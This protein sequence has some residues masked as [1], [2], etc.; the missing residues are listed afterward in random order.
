MCACSHS[1]LFYTYYSIHHMSYGKIGVT[2]VY[3]FALRKTL[4][5]GGLQ[6]PKRRAVKETSERQG[7]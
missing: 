4:E 7:W 2:F 5:G 1:I 6:L 3:K